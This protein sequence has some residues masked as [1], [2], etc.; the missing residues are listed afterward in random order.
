MLMFT[1]NH[2]VTHRAKVVEAV[3]QS[4]IVDFL[5]AE[6]S[7]KPHQEGVSEDFARRS[8]GYQHCRSQTLQPHVHV[9]ATSG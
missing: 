8:R 9:V 6:R 1:Y 3:S 2:V 5:V 4:K 7:L